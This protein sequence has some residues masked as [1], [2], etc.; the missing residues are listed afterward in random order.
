MKISPL[1]LSSL[2]ALPALAQEPTPT[3]A[4][5]APE[6]ETVIVV[7]AERNSQPISQTP[8]TVT[9]VTREQIEAKKPFDIS[10]IVRLSPGVSLAQTGSLGK[11]VS[12]FTR[13]TNSNH[14]LVLIDGIRANSPAD[15]RFDFG[16]IL[17][18]NIERIEVLRGPQSALYGSDAIGGVINIITRRGTGPLKTGA[19]LEIGSDSLQKQ[20]FS[21]RGQVGRGGL[22]FSAT[23]L[24]SGGQSDNDD[25]KNLGASLRYD[26][27]IGKTS[28]LAFIGRFDDAEVGTPGQTNFTIDPNARSKPRESFGN[29]QFTHDAEKRRDKVTFGIADRRLGF[30]DALNP[31]TTPATGTTTDSTNKSRVLSLDAQSAFTLGKN[32]LTVG[33]ESR[34]ERASVDSVA[35]FGGFPFNSQFN[36]GT[37]TNALFVQDEFRSGR[38]TLA[39]GVRYERNSQFGNNTS[40]RFAASFDVDAKSKIK[41]SYGTAFKA[42]SFN[43]LYFPGFGT[44]TLQPEKSRGYEIGYGREIAGS[45]RV[46]ITAFRNRIRNLIAGVAAPTAADPFRFIA[47]NINRAKTQGVE[48]GL[49]LP[50][51]RGVRAVVNQTF[52]STDAAPR[53]LRRPGFNTTADLIAR[54]QKISADLGFIAQG[55]RFDND[56]QDPAFGGTGRGAGVFGGYT[57]FDLTLGY[58]VRPGLEIYG[59]LQNL[60]G[61]DYE[62]AAGFRAPGRN[63]VIGLRTAAF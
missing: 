32:T 42:P 19:G 21:A 5:D 35:S 11:G 61:R 24:K 59:R 45:G 43:D 30:S 41:A 17:A 9:V 36:Q 25:Y 29:V 38:F 2:L 55:R 34:R 48:I 49:D 39:P 8:S 4:P 15:G 54:R 22:S 62:E 40:G 58:D 33:G 23:R 20:V 56:F 46:E 63:F 31:G 16:N 6:N 51:A 13:G 12:I 1:A 7:T 57:R 37:R 27:G 3:P 44:P 28:N 14:T 26:L 18:E 52:L 10:D 53:L 47:A 60:F 50:L